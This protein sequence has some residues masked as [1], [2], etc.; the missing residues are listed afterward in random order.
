M[1]NII[2]IAPPAAGKGTI[3]DYLVENDNYIHIS[4]GDILREE[5][6]KGSE[7]GIK[8]AKI[9]DEGKL[10][11]DDFM[12]KLV[13]NKI[14][15]IK[16]PF[17]LDGFPRTLNQAVKLE[18][19]LKVMNVTNNMVIYLDISLEDAL[20]RVVGRVVCSKCKKTYNTINEKFKPKEM[21][22]CDACGGVLET[23][24]EDNPET[25]KARY[26]EYLKMTKPALDYYQ[27]KGIL[28][29]YSATAD[30]KETLKSIELEAKND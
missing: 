22:I 5:I 27:E 21:G 1:K 29:C 23:R 2:F 9:I 16:D 13:E 3:S 8:L 20:K 4:T 19:L 18:E 12:I 14:T 26:E 17:I 28:K 24:R 25:F 10:V 6:K 30:I 11:D 7:L 15:S